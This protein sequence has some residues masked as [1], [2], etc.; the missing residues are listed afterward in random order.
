MFYALL[1][2]TSLRPIK[3]ARQTEHKLLLEQT[4]LSNLRYL[5]IL[6]VHSI[7]HQDRRDAYLGNSIA[8]VTS[9][10]TAVV[11]R[12]QW[13]HATTVKKL[14]D[15]A[16]RSWLQKLS[17]W[18]CSHSGFII[19]FMWL[20]S[21][22]S[23]HGRFLKGLKGLKGVTPVLEQWPNHPNLQKELRQNLGIQRNAGGRKGE[24]SKKLLVESHI[25]TKGF[26][27]LWALNKWKSVCK[28]HQESWWL[29]MANWC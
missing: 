23:N 27:M 11:K 6:F 20:H 24:W 13:R 8:F 15:V 5:E 7:V 22:Y 18:R 16:S 17:L 26:E 1:I 29:N 25:E 14:R 28:N 2:L 21:L 12:S 9:K 10:G 3:S 4:N 19:T